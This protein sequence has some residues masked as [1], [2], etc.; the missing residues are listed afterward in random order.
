MHALQAQTPSRSGVTPSSVNHRVAGPSAAIQGGHAARILGM[1]QALGNQAVQRLLRSGLIQPKLTVGAPGDVYEQEAE[2]VAERV[3]GMPPP[4]MISGQAASQPGQSVHVQR[5]CAKCEEEMQRAVSVGEQQS[6]TT[7]Q[8]THEPAEVS[9][10]LETRLLGLRGGGDPLPERVRSFFEPRFGRDFSHVRVHADSDA[11]ES[12]RAVQARAYTFGHDIFFDAGEFAIESTHGQ[13][14]LAHELTHVIQQ[15]PAEGRAVHGG[16][17]PLSVSGRID[18]APYVAR[19]PPCPSTTIPSNCTGRCGTGGVCYFK[20]GACG[21]YGSATRSPLPA[22]LVVLLSAAALAL[23]AACFAT[24]ICELGAVVA[25]VGVGLAAVVVG[26]LRAA[27]VTVNDGSTAAADDSA[28]AT[29]DSDQDQGEIA[30]QDEY[31]SD[32]SDAFADSDQ[33]EEALA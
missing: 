9:A 16:A 3:I 4:M 17:E 14:L 27:G 28:D 2:R 12:A 1:Q 15:Q 20:A 26:L 31:G 6:A 18:A 8:G 33:E 32:T 21:C 22:W 13:R 30:S 19:Y 5:V 10:P 23:I 7:A 29:D 11:A 25:A 24:G